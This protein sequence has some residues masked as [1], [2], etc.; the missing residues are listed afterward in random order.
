MSRLRSPLMLLTLL[1]LANLLAGYRVYSAEAERT[2]EDKVLRSI[3]LLMDVFQTVRMNYVDAD[4]VDPAELLRHAVEGMVSSLDPYSAFMP[5]EQT[6]EIMEE[7]EGAFGG[8]G[9]SVNASDGRLMVISTLEGTPAAKAGILSGDQIVGVNETRLEQTTLEESVR[10]LRGPDGSQMVVRIRREGE[11]EELSFTLTRA[12]IPLESVTAVHVL[13]GT[14]FGYLRISQFMDP[15]PGEVQKGLRQLEALKVSGLI[16]DLRN[17]PGGLLS[18]VVEVCSFFLPA[19]ET[20][21]SVEGRISEANYREKSRDG[22]KFP[23][24]CPVVLL[25]NGGSASAAEVMAG[26][27]RDLNRA[28]LVGE[29]SFGKG[30]V[31][32]IKELSDGYALKLTIAKYYTPSRRMIHGH[33]IEPDIQTGLTREVWLKLIE[34]PEADR[35]GA[36]PQLQKAVETLRSFAVYEQIRK[37]KVKVSPPVAT[38]QGEKP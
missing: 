21:V 9:I 8:I 19:G 3:D 5:P 29:K 38:E 1:L 15:T 6:R 25:I 12:L 26:C 31:Q 34:T 27:L 24:A 2:G 20:I 16:I 23:A 28:I 14:N 37:G 13:P 36:D 22:Y 32:N 18:A 7:T 11:A 17:N 10:L 4:R 30:S 33:G 35:L